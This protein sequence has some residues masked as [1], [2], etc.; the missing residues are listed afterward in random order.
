MILRGSFQ[1]I[2]LKAEPPKPC[3]EWSYL[4]AEQATER[5]LARQSCYMSGIA[6]TGKTFFMMQVTKQLEEQGVWVKK[7][8]KFYVAALNVGGGTADAFLHK[9]GNGGFSR[10]KCC[11]VLEEVCVLDTRLLQ[12]LGKRKRMEVQ[13]ICLGCPNQFKPIGS[14]FNGIPTDPDY[15]ASAFLRTLCDGNR[16]HLTES[17]RSGEG[18]LWDFYSSIALD[19]FRFGHS[20]KSKV[21]M[22]KLWFPYKGPTQWNLTVSHAER[23]SI[24]QSL[25]V[26]RAPPGSLWLE[27][28]EKNMANEAQGYWLHKGLILIVY[29]P[30]GVKRGC[31]N[32]QLLEVVGLGLSDAEQQ[33]VFLQDIESKVSTTLP[34]EFVR[35]Y[36]RLAYAFTS[37]GCQGRSLGNEASETEPERGLTI[38]TDSYHFSW[39]HLFTG[40]SRCRSA[41]LL[42]VC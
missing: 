28:S 31:H 24:N 8:A 6:G 7:V 33:E 17:K 9:Y 38:H 37:C 29:L 35:D 34:M 20:L 27:K 1:Q 11:L 21:A 22:A 19:G 12:Q 25:N 18:E 36:L 26:A 3:V 4:T 41:R 15:E 30:C 14:E 10:K 42:R 5:I 16:L 2:V 40:V 32:G 13:Y 39:R 23:L